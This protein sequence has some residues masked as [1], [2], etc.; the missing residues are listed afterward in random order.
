MD[1]VITVP[2]QKLLRLVGL[3]APT[4]GAINPTVTTNQHYVLPSTGTDA[5]KAADF[6]AWVESRLASELRS[7]VI[8]REKLEALLDAE[9]TFTATNTDPFAED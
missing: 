7:K 5:E 2:N 1:I 3:Y 6:K 8:A 4:E 9:E